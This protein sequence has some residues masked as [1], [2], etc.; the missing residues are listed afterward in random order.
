MCTAPLIIR[1]IQI[2]TTGDT[3]YSLE[4]SSVA[5]S[6]PTLR[7]HG[8]QARQ[9]SL[10][11]TSSW[12]LLKLMSIELVMLVLLEWLSSKRQVITCWQGCREKRT[13]G[14]SWWDCKLVQPLWKTVEVPQKT[15]SRLS[16]MTQQFHFWEHSRRKL[17]HWVRAV[18]APP[19]SQQHYL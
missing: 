11:I 12:S 8:L 5:Q 1:E 17:K 16:H 18:T 3:A 15:K 2:Q 6:C 10:S 13:L 4:F 9:A 7:P 14:Q 19:C